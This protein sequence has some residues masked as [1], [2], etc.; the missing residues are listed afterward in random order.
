MSVDIPDLHTLTGAYAAGALDDAERVAFDQHLRECAACREEVA[1]LTATTAR[2]A[3]AAAA[4]APPGLRDRVLAEARRTRQLPPSAEVSRLQDRRRR[5]YQQPA[6][7][8]AALLLVVSAALGGV[9]V[10]ERQQAE[11][12][13]RLASRIAAIAT[14]PDAR[15]VTVRASTS[16]TGTVIAARGSAIFRTADLPELPEGKAYQ[17][18]LLHSDGPQSVGVLGRG[19]VLEALVEDIGSAQGLGLTIEP[20]GGSPAPTSDLVLRMVMA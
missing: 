18:W 5:W 19:G 17:L 1:E 9:A 14:D 12:A 16:G 15:V 7:V 4:P 6:S 2:L 8:A 11:R 13:E 20:A 3:L 10:V